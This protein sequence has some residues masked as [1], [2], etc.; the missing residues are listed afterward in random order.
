M[1]LPTT[2]SLA[3]AA[4]FVNLWHFVRI[5]RIR[6]SDKVLHGDGGNPMLAKRMRAHANFIENAPFALAL[7]A[8]IE[9]AG[10]GGAW[11]GPVGAVYFLARI[12][13]GYGMDSDKENIPRGAGMALTLLIQIGLAI[14]AVLIALG[15]M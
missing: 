15:K 14:V 3:G 6:A 8:L 2:L 11:L 1:L 4:V 10:K 9:L 13:H 12:A 5:V 7:I